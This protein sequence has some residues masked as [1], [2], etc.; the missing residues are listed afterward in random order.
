MKKKIISQL[1]IGEEEL[2]SDFKKINQEIEN[3]YSP[4]FIETN[5]D[6]CVEN[7]LHEEFQSF[8]ENLTF[9]SLAEQE[10]RELEAE[11]NID[12]VQN[13]LNGFQ[14]NKTPGDDGFTK[15]FYEAFFDL[16]GAA[17]LDSF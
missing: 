8:I 11:I 16:V 6:P 9:T 4:I 10:N 3:H 13:T 2:L 1:D 17:L 14:N 7:D 5:I 12:E 15:E